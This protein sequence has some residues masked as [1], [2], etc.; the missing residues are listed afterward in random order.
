MPA[1]RSRSRAYYQESGRAGRDGDPASATLI[2]GAGGFRPRAPADRRG[3]A[4]PPAGRAHAHLGAG[5][6]GRNRG[7]PPRGAAAPFRRGPARQLRQLRQLPLA[8]GQRRRDP[9]RAEAALGGLPHRPELRPR[10]YRGGA[11]RQDRRPDRA[12]RARSRCRCSASSTARKRALIKPVARALLVQ[13][14]ARDQRA[15]R[16]DA[17]PRR[18]RDPQGRGDAS[19]WS[20]RP[21]R[22]SAARARNGEANPV[23]DPMFEALRELRRELAK[24]GRRAALCDLPRQHAARAGAEAPAERC[25]P[26]RTSAASARASARPM[27]RPFSN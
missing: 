4:A 10:P 23:G 22:R 17:R 18:P 26:G 14:R 13:R 21:R 5:R 11:D 2:W 25:R 1:C 12:A 27:A 8:A 16:A 9:D 19:R 6:A 3:R 24:R 7:L 15:W 20:C